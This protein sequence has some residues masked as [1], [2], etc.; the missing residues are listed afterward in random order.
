MSIVL[1]IL[2]L[3][4]RDTFEFTEARNPYMDNVVINENNAR[5]AFEYLKLINDAI[6]DDKRAELLRKWGSIGPLNMLLSLNFDDRIK[7]DFPEGAPPYNRNETIHPDTATPLA[8]Q[9]GRLKGCVMFSGK[10]A[11]L[12]RK[13]D[14]ERVL[15]QILE[16]VAYQEADVLIAAKDKQLQELYPKITKELVKS[17]FPNYVGQ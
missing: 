8:G 15:I 13:L 14:R 16:Q 6:S 10:P 1:D 7:L 2:N 4:K 11:A 9:I 12:G 3:F 5:H 17:I